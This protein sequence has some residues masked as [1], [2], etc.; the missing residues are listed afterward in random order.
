[1][2]S[3]TG[4]AIPAG[5]APQDFNKSSA[6]MHHQ[7]PANRQGGQ[8]R[9]PRSSNTYGTGAPQSQDARASPAPS[10]HQM[11]FPGGGG[12]GNR[13]G[14]VT[15]PVDYL[16]CEQQIYV[17]NLP[18]STSELDLKEFFETSGYGGVLDTRVR[19]KNP[20]GHQHNQQ[21]QCFAFVAFESSETAQKLILKKML[22]YR[23]VEIIID[24]K[25]NMNDRPGGGGGGS[26]NYPYNG[27]RPFTGA[28]GMPA[29]GGGVGGGVGRGGMGPS[30]GGMGRG[31]GGGSASNRPIG[32]G[33]SGGFIQGGGGGVNRQQQA[34]RT[35]HGRGGGNAP[36]PQ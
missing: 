1:M 8:Y 3:P 15:T 26:G 13:P 12:G 14:Q 9:G 32:Q 30:R 35:F 22:I 31:G 19:R 5:H 33:G 36:H 20:G 23:G 18:M 24:V 6:A 10:G 2:L 21:Q 25:R 34:S 11:D 16:P 4:G 28:A 17:R 29:G 7:H 27:S